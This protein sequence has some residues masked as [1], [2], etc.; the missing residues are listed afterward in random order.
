MNRRRFT[1]QLAPA[2][3]AIS[4]ARTTRGAT[5]LAP[6]PGVD[7]GRGL[8]RGMDLRSDASAK[9]SPCPMSC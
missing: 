4:L 8:Y 5:F 1:Q 6:A 2:I 7:G 3:G 9:E